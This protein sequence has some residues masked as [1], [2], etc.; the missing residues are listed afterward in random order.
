MK[1]KTKE[2]LINEEPEPSFPSEFDQGCMI[3]REDGVERAFEFFKERIDFYEKYAY[4][5]DTL[6]TEQP[7]VFSK[8]IESYEFNNGFKPEIKNKNPLLA[9]EYYRDW[10][11][12]Y[13]FGDIE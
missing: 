1:F 8:W 4:H 2:D 10:L 7:K 11:F 5:W 6:K 3:G 13:C 12:D 9:D